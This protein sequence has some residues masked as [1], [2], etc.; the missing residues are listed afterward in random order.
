MASALLF[1][2]DTVDEIDD[3][4]EKL[5]RLGRK[6]ILWVDLESPSEDEVRQLVDEL[7]VGEESVRLLEDAA[8]EP[9]LV[10]HGEYVHVR[11]CAPSDAD[12][13]ELRRLDCLV[14]ERWVVTVHD[15][16]VAVLETFRERATG[17][18][19][20]GNLDGPTFLADLL[21][22]TL[23]GYLD[24]FEAIEVL[25]EDIDVD[26]MAQ[27]IETKEEILERLV[28][29]R[30]EIGHLRRALASHRELTL[31]LARPELEAIA[32]SSSVDRFR[33]LRDQLEVV[34]QAARDSRESVVGSFEVLIATTGQR[35]NEIMKVLTLASVLLLPGA[36]VAGI[37]GMNFKVGLFDHAVLFWATI[38][39]ILA[40]AFATIA[41]ARMRDWV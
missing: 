9:T 11:S 8:A 14:S 1:D 17:S 6:C 34:V 28:A 35:T 36:L 20:T 13:R 2:R 10:D 22:W 26:A 25:L 32:S 7:G 3:W 24:A 4:T 41:A 31:A 38:A 39:F 40:V 12:E 18:G 37:M 23:A 15:A 33:S 19:A 16:P 29:L 30:R 5:P 27:R 21:E